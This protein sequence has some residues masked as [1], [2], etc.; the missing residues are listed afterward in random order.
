MEK[1]HDS[2]PM[3]IEDKKVLIAELCSR[4]PY[5]VQIEH[6]PTGIQGRL[7]NINVTHIYNDTDSI[8]DIKACI[9]FFGEDN[10]DATYFRPILRPIASMT[11]EEVDRLFQILKINEDKG[12]EWLK[13]N[14][15]GIIRL[16]TEEGKDFY[17]I[18]EAI[19]YLYSIHIDFKGLISTG[20][21]LEA[22]DKTY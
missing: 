6:V 2:N 7:N 18:D 20:L 11:D 14:D 12:T 13:V 4:L 17:E 16:F 21:A 1:A 10:V 5:G 9:T 22:T 8:Q 3:A 15:V 19:N